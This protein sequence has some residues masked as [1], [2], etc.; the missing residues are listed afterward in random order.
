M[1][2]KWQPGRLYFPGDLVRP[3]GSGDIDN[4][5]LENLDFQQGDT[6]WTFSSNTTGADE[7]SENGNAFVGTW[8]ALVQDNGTG[9]PKTMINAGRQAVKPGEPVKIT[10]YV[11]CLQVPDDTSCRAVIHWFN[12]AGQE[13]AP[14]YSFT[15]PTGFLRGTQAQGVWVGLTVIGTAPAEAVEFAPGAEFYWFPDG[16][17]AIG[18]VVVDAATQEAPNP[19]IFRATQAA[20]GYSGNSEPAWPD[21]V[22][23]TV[24]DNEV[25]WTAV[26]NNF[27]VWEARRILVTGSVQPSWPVGVPGASVPDGSINWMLDPRR[28][29][30]ENLPQS[31]IV[32]LGASKIFAADGDIIRFSATVNP[33][34]WTTRE[35]AG[36]LPVGLQQYGSNPVTAIGL[37]RGNLA[38]FN[39]EGCQIWQIDP[40]PAAMTLLDAIPVP[41]RWPKTVQPVGDDLALLSN[42]GIR[43]LALVGASVNL[44]GGHFGQQ[45]DPLVREL[46]S[47]LVDAG[48]EPRS[49]YWPAHG[50]YWCI[51]GSE[52]L[53]LTINGP[54]KDKRSWSRYTFPGPIDHWT[55][56]GNDLYLRSGDL[57][58]R[59]SDDAIYDDERP[60]TTTTVFAVDVELGLVGAGLEVGWEDSGSRAF[61]STTPAPPH[62]VAGFLLEGLYVDPDTFSDPVF[63]ARFAPGGDGEETIRN[64]TIAAYAQR[65]ATL[66]VEHPGGELELELSAATTPYGA[67]TDHL[68]AWDVDDP[69]PEADVGELRGVRLVDAA[70]G[71]PELHSKMA[72]YAGRPYAPGPQELIGYEALSS[73]GSLM[74]AIFNGSVYQIGRLA[75]VKFAG[76]GTTNFFEIRCDDEA[77]FNYLA[78]LIA[79]GGYL[80]IEAP[81]GNT[82]EDGWIVYPFENAT[83]GTP[84]TPPFQS[85]PPGYQSIY[86]P[87]GE[88]A[89]GL[90]GGWTSTDITNE[91]LL[92][93]EWYVMSAEPALVGED[94]VG[95]IQ[96]PHL[97]LGEFGTD[98]E[99]IAFDLVMRG[100]AA[101]TIGWDETQQDYDPSGP[102]TEPYVVDGDTLPKDKIP[103][104]VTGPSLALRL[105]FEPGQSWEWTAANL[106]VND[107]RKR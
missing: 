86:F 90:T 79:R 3:V 9:S 56:L 22:G 84:S 59:M 28:V 47:E 50:Q 75:F 107:T 16:Q 61:G 74:P 93:V 101:I 38:A 94:I 21:T 63:V 26:A 43:S 44:Q 15:A 87:M 14:S 66:I 12:G 35:D 100:R 23:Q 64:E 31:P 67:G 92:R 51:F 104:E 71:E 62:V 57:V 19:L 73:A 91:T 4:T 99:L 81:T 32:M 103:L 97:D 89:D 7:I 55:I 45:V 24:A 88:D 85:D 77:T 78:G 1:V 60:D 11:K 27:I 6:G 37:Y 34:D 82:A 102:W 52:A 54:G 39:T 10:I 69:W 105:E 58:W 83:F 46:L 80:R 2:D 18:K 96:W 17:W 25:T 40:D 5:G 72:V 65:G 29:T 68:L 8:S 20:A 70:T 41:C 13:L 33:L 53:V 49:L 30:D 36:F 95:V 42:V 98:K 48:L 76:W 106:Y